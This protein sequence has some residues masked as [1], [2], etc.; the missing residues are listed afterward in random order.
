MVFIILPLHLTQIKADHDTRSTENNDIT[1]VYQTS[2]DNISM[3]DTKVG[4]KLFI[5]EL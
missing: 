3:E 1:N 5:A 2:N 4:Q